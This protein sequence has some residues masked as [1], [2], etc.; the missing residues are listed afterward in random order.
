MSLTLRKQAQ[1]ILDTNNLQELHISINNNNKCLTLT[2]ECGEPFITISGILFS[3][4]TPNKSE[5]DYACELLDIFITKHKITLLDAINIARKVKQYPEQPHIKDNLKYDN[6]PNKVM[7]TMLNN[8]I[9]NIYEDLR[10]D[11]KTKNNTKNLSIPEFNKLK[12]SEDICTKVK[13]IFK[14]NNEYQKLLTKKDEALNLL[15][16]CNI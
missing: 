12:I 2:G 11:I 16:K 9:V 13:D 6:Y 5:I 7:F 15:N 1:S 8:L 14:W 3:R 10:I 4:N